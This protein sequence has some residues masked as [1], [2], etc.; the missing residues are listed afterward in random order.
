M[1][2][3]DHKILAGALREQG[4]ADCI[5][6]RFALR[7]VSFPLFGNPTTLAH[8][9]IGK[10]QQSVEKLL[11]GYLL[12]HSGAFDPTKGHRP[13]TETLTLPEKQR[14]VIEALCI[15]LNQL[16]PRVVGQIKWLENLAPHPPD[17]PEAE[18]GNL[19]PL[20]GIQENAEYPYWS[21]PH[22][23]LVIAAEGLLLQD[24]GVQAIKAVRTLLTALASSDP[25][26]YTKPIAEFLETYPFSTAVSEW[27]EV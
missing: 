2:W 24:Q 10:S 13:L 27:P 5:A 23:R 6:A 20:T 22:N 25:R 26:A 1:N 12:W 18:R 16:N 7:P 21:A 14:G 11:K 17:V 4:L 9:V 3:Q 15:R 19:Q 8:V